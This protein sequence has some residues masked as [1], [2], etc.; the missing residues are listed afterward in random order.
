MTHSMEADGIQLEFGRKRILSDI[1]IKCET[2]K[3]TGILGR[4]GEGKSCLMNTIYGSLKNTD[5]SVRF[6][7]IPISHPFKKSNL[8]LYLPQFNFIPTFLRIKRAFQDFNI[9]FNDFEHDFPDYKLK[10]KKIRF[11]YLKMN[12]R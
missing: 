11:F 7:G 10:Y 9:D 4:N 3:I 8:L 5:K 2:G 1:Y 6:D 12:K